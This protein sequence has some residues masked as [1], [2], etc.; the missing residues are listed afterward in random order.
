MLCYSADRS[1]EQGT[2]ALC[3]DAIGL[4]ELAPEELVGSG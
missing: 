4:L 3:Q 1:M 2:S